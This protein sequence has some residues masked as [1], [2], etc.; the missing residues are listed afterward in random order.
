MARA[1]RRRHHEDFHPVTP[2]LHA[3]DGESIEAVTLLLDNGADATRS[4]REAAHL[5]GPAGLDRPRSTICRP[6]SPADAQSLGPLGADRTI[7]ELLIAHGLDLN[8]PIRD[9]KPR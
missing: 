6:R 5:G 9:R 2:L 3:V 7:S 4:G 8:V 1:R